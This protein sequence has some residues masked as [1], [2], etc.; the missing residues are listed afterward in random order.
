VAVLSLE[1]YLAIFAHSRLNGAL[2]FPLTNLFCGRRFLIY[3]CFSI[4][5]VLF[6]EKVIFYFFQLF[7]V[8][9]HSGGCYLNVG[10][11]FS[12]IFNPDQTIFFNLIL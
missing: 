5:I 1:D 8:R 12:T 9:I 3:F 4:D 11:T 2:Y 6:M 7:S 10:E